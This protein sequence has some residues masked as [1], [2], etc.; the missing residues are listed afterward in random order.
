L[1]DVF[2]GIGL[3]EE[4]GE[5]FD[6]GNFA[7]NVANGGEGGRGKQTANLAAASADSDLSDDLNEIVQSL[8]EKKCEKDKR[9]FEK[10]M[11]QSKQ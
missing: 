9:L 2:T 7:D 10:P 8:Q 4:L 5:L 6:A 3:L 1:F 11:K